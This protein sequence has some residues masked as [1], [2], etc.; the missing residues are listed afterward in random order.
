MRYYR[1]GN[2]GLKVSVVGLGGN[3]FGRKVDAEGAARIVHTA[4]DL[5]VNFFDTADVYSRGVSEEFYGR[6]L[7]GRRNQAILATKVHG[8]MGDGPNDQGSSRAHIMDGVDASL[9]RLNMD[10]IDLLQLH[11]WD[12]QTPIEETLGALN[13]LVR[14]GKV[15]YIGCSNFSAWQLVWSLWTS[16][17]RNWA[18]FVSVQPEY[19]LLAREAEDELLPA[20]RAFGIGMIP[21]F[22]LAAGVLTGKYREGELAPPGTR[23]RGSERFQRRFATPRNLAIVRRLEVWAQDHGHT[24][25]ELAIAWLAARPAVASV[26]TGV[27]KPEQVQANVRAADWELTPSEAEEVAVLAPR[28]GAGTP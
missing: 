5:G 24:V 4:L 14:L 3:P 12:D 9:R 19:S 22:P 6:A 17:R 15:R 13:D 16:D 18:P 25:G 10:R 2:S 23:G 20:C 27:T 21:Y 11:G 7:A 8:A 26:I 28:D 1:L